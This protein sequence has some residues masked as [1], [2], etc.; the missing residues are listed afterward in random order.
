[1]AVSQCQQGFEQRKLKV[2][3]IS[4]FCEWEKVKKELLGLW[5]FRQHKMGDPKR[6]TAIQVQILRTVVHLEK[7]GSSE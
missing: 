5:K 7:S 2:I 6:E 1:M 3:S 4:F